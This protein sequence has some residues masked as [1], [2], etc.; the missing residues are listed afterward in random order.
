MC[1][2]VFHDE[3]S[4]PVR[5][6]GF[7]INIIN[8]NKPDDVGT[9]IVES[10]SQNS[11]YT[12]TGIAGK[13]GFAVINIEKDMMNSELGFGRRVLEVFEKNGVSFEHMPSGIDTMSVIVHLDDVD[14]KEQDAIEIESELALVAV[15]GRGMKSNRGT[16]GRIFSS[17][18]H[19][20]VNVKMI[21]QGSSELN[22]IVGV[23]EEDFKTAIKAI[24]DIF[25][26]QKL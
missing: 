17:L 10:T 15:V 3:A 13:K 21:D 2:T 12:I 6:E 4:F 18:A 14:E 22:I 11:E 23:K 5:K 1:A 7:T 8:T 16:A 20:H 26:L 24:Y 19:N 9:M 25:V